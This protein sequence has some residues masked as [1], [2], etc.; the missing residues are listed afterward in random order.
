MSGALLTATMVL[1]GCI[2]GFT[3]TAGTPNAAIQ[4]VYVAGNVSAGAF[5]SQFALPTSVGVNVAPT[6]DIIGTATTLSDAHRI[7]FDASGNMYVTD[8]DSN[9]VDIFAAGATGNVAPT[10]SISGGNT[11]LS[12]PSGIALDSTGKIYVVNQFNNV[13][14]TVYAAGAT[15]NATPVATI[16]GGSTGLVEPNGIALDSTG[17]I[18]VCDE[19]NSSTASVTVYA[20]NPV[21]NITSA[22]LAT[23]MGANTGLNSSHDLTLDSSGNIYVVNGDDFGGAGA[24]TVDVFAAGATGNVAPIAVISGSNTAFSDPNGISVDASGK[25]YVGNQKAIE[26]FAA[27]PVGTLNEAP[28]ATS[29]GSN[30]GITSGVIHGVTV[31]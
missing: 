9:K 27:N 6:T 19:R 16:S 5:A 26:V 14:V 12:S 1:T 17:K 18:Y 7:A 22:P 3:Y 29:S 20:A 28:I 4:H 23:I 21:G 15:G 31:H 2:A 13:S 10:S 30:T 25:I 8:H 24:S 11:G